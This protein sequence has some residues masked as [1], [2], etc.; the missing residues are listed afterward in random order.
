MKYVIT[1]KMII[2]HEIDLRNG[3]LT[4]ENLEKVVLHKVLW[5][6]GAK[7]LQGQKPMAAILDFSVILVIHIG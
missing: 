1:L 3:F 2:K 4:S 6:I 5:Q 7:L